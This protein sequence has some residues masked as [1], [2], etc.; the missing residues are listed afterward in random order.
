MTLQFTANVIP[1]I[2]NGAHGGIDKVIILTPVLSIDIL[3]FTK[4]V[5]V[6]L[7]HCKIGLLILK[8]CFKK[9]TFLRHC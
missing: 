3:S 6:D 2:L 5:E 8:E 4:Q 9:L 7:K 1:P